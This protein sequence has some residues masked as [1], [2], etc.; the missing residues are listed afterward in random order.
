M[1]GS[2]VGF[3]Y[4]TRIKAIQTTTKGNCVCKLN[5]GMNKT[6]RKRYLSFF[7][8]LRLLY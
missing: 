5:T 6:I 4:G 2:N 3:G 8:S 7:C 1:I